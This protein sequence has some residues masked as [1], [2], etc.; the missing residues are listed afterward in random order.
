[1][2]KEHGMES[3]ACNKAQEIMMRE[4]FELIRSARDRN[5]AEI[6]ANG[7]LLA[8]VIAASLMEASSAYAENTASAMK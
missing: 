1:M 5:P 8:K 7:M 4:G 3:W 6:R 2:S